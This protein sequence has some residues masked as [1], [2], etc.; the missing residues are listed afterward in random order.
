MQMNDAKC[1]HYLVIIVSSVISALQNPTQILMNCSD[2]IKSMYE[3]FILLLFV[4]HSDQVNKQQ[5][6]T[7]V[8]TQTYSTTNVDFWRCFKQLSDK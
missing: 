7:T 6:F 8:L 2:Y 3:K 4:V 5:T 1:F